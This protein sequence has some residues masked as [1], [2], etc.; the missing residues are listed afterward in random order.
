MQVWNQIC[1]RIMEAEI[2]IYIRLLQFGPRDQTA[3]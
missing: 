3:V 1:K 2:Y